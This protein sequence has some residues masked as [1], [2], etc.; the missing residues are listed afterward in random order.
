LLSELRQREVAFKHG[1]IRGKDFSL[2]NIIIQWTCNLWRDSAQKFRGLIPTLV[3]KLE[4][5]KGCLWALKN[6]PI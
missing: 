5:E 4:Y 3:N 2:C 6:K 1:I